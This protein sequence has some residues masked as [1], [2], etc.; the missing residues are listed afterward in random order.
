[1]H[2]AGA[3]R[4]PP[5][6]AGGW[7]GDTHSERTDLSSQFTPAFNC[8]RIWG[9]FNGKFSYCYENNNFMPLF[10]LN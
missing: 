6:V 4:R 10:F 2:T 1:M 7:G 3:A 5:A 8:L 9:R